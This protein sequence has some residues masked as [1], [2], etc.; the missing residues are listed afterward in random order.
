[1]PSNASLTETDVA[2]RKMQR[3]I[4]Q[5][6]NRV[7]SLERTVRTLKSANHTLVHRVASLDRRAGALEA[8]RK[9]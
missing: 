4:D 5:L 8:S 6:V 7:S 9:S 2:L 3:T 1:M